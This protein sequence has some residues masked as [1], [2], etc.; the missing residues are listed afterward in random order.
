MGR[1]IVCFRFGV[2]VTVRGLGLGFS[3]R[4][5]GNG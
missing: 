5:T 3:V 2:R 1:V 4:F